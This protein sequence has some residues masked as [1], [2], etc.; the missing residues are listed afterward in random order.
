[1][2][3]TDLPKR[4]Q[5][6]ALQMEEDF[7]REGIEELAEMESIPE[8]LRETEYEVV[9]DEEGEEKLIKAMKA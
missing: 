9:R 3:Y 6:I 1:M 2:K 5:K 8:A 4:W 7:V